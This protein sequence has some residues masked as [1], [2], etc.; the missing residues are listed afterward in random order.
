[1]ADDR[2]FLDELIEERTAQNP[3]FP[4]LVAA[5]ENRRELFRVL[6]DNRKAQSLSQTAVAAT[7]HTSQS[8]LARLETSA[9]DTR[10]STVERYAAALGLRIEYKL[11]PVS[12][13]PAAA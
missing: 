4:A 2:D 7:M 12:R 8:S 3:E 1:M 5:A 10:L 11:V 13:R 9:A 6:A